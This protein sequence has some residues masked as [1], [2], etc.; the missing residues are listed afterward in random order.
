MEGQNSRN[1][2]GGREKG[3]NL[4]MPPIY[5]TNTRKEE[6]IM[7]NTTLLGMSGAGKPSASWKK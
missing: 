2:F 5:H 7:N 3:F 4:K 1:N 6:L